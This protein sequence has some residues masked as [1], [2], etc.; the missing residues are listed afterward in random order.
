MLSL[1]QKDEALLKY[2]MLK[3]VEYYWYI[4]V[5]VK[6]QCLCYR[7][8]WTNFCMRHGWCCSSSVNQLC[9]MTA[10]SIYI[11]FHLMKEQYFHSQWFNMAQKW[12]I[13]LEFAK[14][15][16][17]GIVDSP[18]KSL[19]VQRKR[20]NLSK[21]AVNYRSVTI[22][23]LENKIDLDY[24][25]EKLCPTGKS[26]LNED[27]VLAHVD[28][29][30][31][32]S[33]FETRFIKACICFSQSIH[34]LCW[35]WLRFKLH[36]QLLPHVFYEPRT[37]HKLCDFTIAL[38]IIRVPDIPPL[39]TKTPISWLLFKGWL[40]LAPGTEAC[41]NI[42]TQEHFSHF[43]HRFK[44][45]SKLLYSICSFLEALKDQTGKFGKAILTIYTLLKLLTWVKL[46]R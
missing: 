28:I 35:F 23:L 27:T 40:K 38:G 7:G 44:R 3:S 19:F 30:P 1:E 37:N 25:I 8:I 39:K 18:G 9:W 31:A 34:T 22:R 13:D 5:R 42:H 4:E 33:Y 36:K 29:T 11:P 45:A 12:S 17:L 6:M 14:I 24:I 32:V 10:S 26:L 46:A 16:T 20:Q 21:L 15:L 2:Y 43:S 41:F